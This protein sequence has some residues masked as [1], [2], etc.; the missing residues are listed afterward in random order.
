MLA[1]QF[2]SMLMLLS[3]SGLLSAMWSGTWALALSQLRSSSLDVCS[4][5]ALVTCL[6]AWRGAVLGCGLNTRRWAVAGS[7]GRG[8][9]GS[10]TIR[11]C[12]WPTMLTSMRPRRWMRV[13]ER[14]CCKVCRSRSVD[15]PPIMLPRVTWARIIDTSPRMPL[16]MPYCAAAT[17]ACWTW[18]AVTFCWRS[19]VTTMPQKSSCF[20]ADARAS[21]TAPSGSEWTRAGPNSATS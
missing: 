5:P 4:R 15:A 20:A 6:S 18:S 16:D 19:L 1:T 17:S 8:I 12:P 21:P 7:S 14:M 13:R 11:S 10:C 2:T 9:S 3:A